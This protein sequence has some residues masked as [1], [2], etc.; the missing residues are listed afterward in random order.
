MLVPELRIHVDRLGL[1]GLGAGESYLINTAL[2]ST[3]CFK[4]NFCA[5]V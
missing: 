1:R 4:Q 5:L 2:L 3:I